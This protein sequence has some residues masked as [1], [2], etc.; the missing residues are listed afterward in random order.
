MSMCGTALARFPF[1]ICPPTCRGVRSGPPA[2][3]ALRAFLV[4]PGAWVDPASDSGTVLA[5]DSYPTLPEPK[6]TRLLDPCVSFTVGYR[7]GLERERAGV[8]NHHYFFCLSLK[9]KLEF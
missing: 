5:S 7:F 6:L 2:K 4:R 1:A 3:V 9:E 8:K